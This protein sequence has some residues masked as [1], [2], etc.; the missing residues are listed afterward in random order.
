MQKLTAP[1]SYDYVAFK[2]SLECLFGLGALGK[3][4]FLVP[5]H[6]VRAQVTS[7]VEEK[8]GHQ[9]Y[10]VVIDSEKSVPKTTTLG[11]NNS[12]YTPVRQKDDGMFRYRPPMQL[13]HDATAHQPQ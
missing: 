11:S 13:Q 5:F 9:N 6:I 4:K 3:I 2:R 7:S 1:R 12:T 10:I 8:T